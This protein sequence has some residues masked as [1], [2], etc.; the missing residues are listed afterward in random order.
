MRI[1]RLAILTDHQHQFVGADIHAGQQ[2]VDRFSG[3]I[4]WEVRHNRFLIQLHYL[5]IPDRTYLPCAC[6]L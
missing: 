1:E 6:R 4:D 5:P 2:A 3:G